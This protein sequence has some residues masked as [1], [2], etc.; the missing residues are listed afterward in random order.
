M[1]RI[2]QPDGERIA[3]LKPRAIVQDPELGRRAGGILRIVE[4]F[5]GGQTLT[6]PLFVLPLGI[7]LLDMCTVCQ[8][9]CSQFRRRAG[10]VNRSLKPL[11]DQQR[12][13]TGMVNV[14]V[15][16][17]NVIDLGCGAG[18]FLNQI[19]IRSLKHPEIHQK[20]LAP[21]LNQMGRAGDCFRRAQKAELHHDASLSFPRFAG[22]FYYF[23]CRSNHVSLQG[24]L[25]GLG[26]FCH[27]F[28]KK[29][30]FIASFPV[31]FKNT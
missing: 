1:S 26:V 16:R 15:G 28:Q 9:N 8:Q 7:H 23:Y 13:V 29:P 17:H 10:A 5:N 31:F 18:Q 4:R 12:Q 25:S 22:L 2:G 19:R 27:L 3:E 24:L 30:L 14:G 6:L 20:A 11:L 21:R